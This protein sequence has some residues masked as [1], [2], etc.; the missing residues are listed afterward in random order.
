MQQHQVD[1]RIGRKI[2]ATVPAMSDKR[3]G[4][5]IDTQPLARRLDQPQNDRINRIGPSETDLRS[6]GAGGMEICSLD[7][8]L[9]QLSARFDD[10]RMKRGQVRLCTRFVRLQRVI[11][12]FAGSD[13]DCILEA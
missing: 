13:T 4:R 12:F 1:V 2:P 11:S 3:D 8:R 9:S 5:S 10:L 6:G 7:A